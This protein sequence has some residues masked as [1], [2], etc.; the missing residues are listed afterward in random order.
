MSTYYAPVW[1]DSGDELQ[2]LQIIF[3]AKQANFKTPWSC[4]TMDN[5]AVVHYFVRVLEHLFYSSRN[6]YCRPRCGVVMKL[7]TTATGYDEKR[8]V[9]SFSSSSTHTTPHLLT[10]VPPRRPY[11]RRPPAL[12]LR[13]PALSSLDLAATATGSP[14]VPPWPRHPSLPSPHLAATADLFLHGPAC[15][16]LGPRRP[17]SRR[18]GPHSCSRPRPPPWGHCQPCSSAGSP[19]PLSSIPTSSACRSCSGLP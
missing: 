12:G 8:F 16:L 2:Q 9:L 3:F 11:R 5:G 4:K 17:S 14:F 19:C 7:P 10:P 1:H 13:H 15:D 18:C 6:I